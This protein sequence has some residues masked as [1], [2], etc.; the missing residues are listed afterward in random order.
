MFCDANK[1]IGRCPLGAAGDF[2]T[3]GNCLA[4]HLPEDEAPDLLAPLIDGNST[5]YFVKQPQTGEEFDR[6]CKAIVS[7]CVQDLR[8]GGQ[9]RSVIL[10]L[11]NSKKY[12]DYIIR[13][14]QVESVR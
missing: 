1:L 4:C 12:C 9:D 8:Y 14:G 11:G 7:C 6:A 5:T 10:R 2:Y 13:N 3:L